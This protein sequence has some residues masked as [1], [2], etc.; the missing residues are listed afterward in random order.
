MILIEINWKSNVMHK[1]TPNIDNGNK[2]ITLRNLCFY[3]S[4]MIMCTLCILYTITSP[5]ECQF[6]LPNK[7]RLSC[8]NLLFDYC[9]MINIIRTKEVA[10]I[11][12]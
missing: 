12:M 11:I 6:Y 8:N 5:I 7:Q 4:K 2:L 9:K 10:K 3:D 1:E